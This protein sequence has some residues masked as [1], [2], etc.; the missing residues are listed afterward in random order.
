MCVLR[1]RGHCRSGSSHESDNPF[2]K[3][4]PQENDYEKMVINIYGARDP[5]YPRMGRR[6]DRLVGDR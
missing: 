3:N 6:R 5:I 1:A 2:Y 4:T